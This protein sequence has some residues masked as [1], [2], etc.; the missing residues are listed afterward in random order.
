M[1]LRRSLSGLLI[2]TAALLVSGCSAAGTP[3]SSAATGSGVPG[4]RIEVKLTDA[5]KIEPATF[6]V[7][8]G[9]PVTFV[10]TN[11][12][13]LEHEF[14]IGDE[15]AQSDHENE[16]AGHGA[17]VMDEPTGIA[18]KP[19]QTKEMTVT[20]KDAGSILAGCHVPGHYPAGMKATVI[21][22]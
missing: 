20:I 16:M 8:A 18:V 6:A 19:G 1:K 2:V 5:M 17:M 9:V 14:F 21:V 11:T 13:A 10:V 7:K 3:A 22:Q 12:W 15:K 4:T